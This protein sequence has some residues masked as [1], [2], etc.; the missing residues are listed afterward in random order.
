M[1]VG[2]LFVSLLSIVGALASGATSAPRATLA[3]VY[4]SCLKHKQAALTFDDGPYLW[5]NDISK[6]LVAAGAKGTFFFNGN[7]Y[8]CIYDAASQK[9]VQY[10]YNHGHQI[11][12]HTWA[13]LDLTTLSSDRIH[14][15][16]WRVEQALQ[17]IVGITPAFMRPPYGNYNNLVRQVVLQR[18]QSLVMWDLDSGD[19]TGSTVAQSEQIYS[20]AVAKNPTNLLPL[21]H[22]THSST[23]EQVVPYAIKLLQSKGYQLVTVAECLGLQAYTNV[24]TPGT[25]EP[26]WVC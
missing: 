11:G 7:N 8:A 17:R 16:M 24:T 9:R 2:F 25:P 20:Q 23:A 4:S 19:S 15:E 10:A 14:D 21:N 12:S 18:N 26:S 13:H 6:F 22:E 3:T 1:K 5:L